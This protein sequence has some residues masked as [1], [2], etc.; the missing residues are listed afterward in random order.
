M[1]IELQFPASRLHLSAQAAK[2]EYAL[3]WAQYE[4]A[5]NRPLWQFSGG[6]RPDPNPQNL[7]YWRACR[8]RLHRAR[9]LCHT[10]ALGGT[11]GN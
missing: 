8:D 3:A 11:Y 4:E 9:D 1:A 7:E 5:S 2:E 6:H 10:A